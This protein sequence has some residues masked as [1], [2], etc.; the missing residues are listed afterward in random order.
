[1]RLPRAAQT[2]ISLRSAFPSHRCR[3]SE[4]MYMS[5]GLTAENKRP[6]FDLPH[7]Q[8]RLPQQIL[9]LPA[10]FNGFARV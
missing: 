3:A 6:S 1:V 7:K 4:A 2:I 5:L 8:T 10:F 9:P